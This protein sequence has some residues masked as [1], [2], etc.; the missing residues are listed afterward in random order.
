MHHEISLVVDERFEVGESPVW[1]AQTG[2]LLWCDVL[3]GAIH[4]LHVDSDQRRCWQ[5]GEP[6]GSFGLCKSGRLVVALV[7]D[8]VL[9]DPETGARDRLAHIDHARTNMR[10]NDG[11]VGPDGAFWVG[12]LHPDAGNTPLGALYRIAPS[13][14]VRQ[15]AEGIAVSNGL[16]WNAQADLLFHADTRGDLWIDCWD[17]DPTDGT[18]R[19]R[20]RF[21]DA[22]DTIGRADGGACD[23]AGAYW[24]CAPW[25]NR[26]NRFDVSGNLVDWIDL[27]IFRP[28][29]A[30]FGGHDMRTIF[31]TS[32]S[33]GVD[34]DALSRFPKCGAIVSFRANI[35]G[36]EIA[37]FADL[38]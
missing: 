15:V 12:S 4:A 14:E 27:P 3:R 19:N 34:H 18:T 23:R 7:S 5:M 9:L 30:C 16:A 25:A 32:L 10:L 22:G 36:V 26:I 13:G 1:N 29:A 8:I 17:F 21:S 38:D 20:R 24:S 37:Q 28:T 11:K 2:E 6:V 35:P 31:V 33:F